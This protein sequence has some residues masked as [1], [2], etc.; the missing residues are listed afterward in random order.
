MRC[1][2]AGSALAVRGDASVEIVGHADVEIAGAACENVD[3][4]VEFARHRWILAVGGLG[5]H[6]TSVAGM[7]TAGSLRE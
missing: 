3:P 2:R 4:E 6:D 5:G 1:V 7:M